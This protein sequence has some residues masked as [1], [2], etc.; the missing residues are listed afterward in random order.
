[1]VN[2]NDWL[3]MHIFYT[4][5]ENALLR[6]CLAPLI[7]D[8]F[9]EKIIDKYFFIRYPEKGQHIR[10]RLKLLSINS[11]VLIRIESDIRRFLNDNPSVHDNRP[12]SQLQNN[13][14]Y[15]FEYVPE[16][17]RYG[18]VKA[19]SLSETHFMCS[20]NLVID[21]IKFGSSGNSYMDAIMKCAEAHFIYAYVITNGVLEDIS[22][23][24]DYIFK[25]TS[26]YYND[27]KGDYKNFRTFLPSSYDECFNVIF[28]RLFALLN[29]LKL[30]SVEK[31]Y[32]E[33]WRIAAGEMLLRL[34]E[35]DSEFSITYPNTF[36]YCP[37]WTIFQSHIHM[38]N[39]RFGIANVD[40]A[41]ISHILRESTL[42][43]L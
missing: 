1:M 37:S 30:D 3:S 5:D 35:L 12:A 36:P 29:Q 18:G 9:S 28:P 42:K 17:Q 2:Q 40:E 11:E 23:F 21:C 41:M 26:D 25:T 38:S 13:Q 34:K 43:L 20:S 22:I 27:A 24:F 16:Y 10:L 32:H 8:L 19:I 15:Y 7:R 14:V 4:G 31:D 39:N 6:D 33:S